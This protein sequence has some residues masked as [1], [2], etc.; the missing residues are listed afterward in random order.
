[1]KALPKSYVARLQD[2]FLACDQPLI[3]VWGWPWSGKRRL[4]EALAVEDPAAWLGLEPGELQDGVTGSPARWLVTDG[5]DDVAVILA[6]AEA[7]REDQRLLLPGERRLADEVLP[8]RSLQPPDLL[9][10]ADEIEEMFPDLAA[11]RVDELTRATDGWLGPLEWLLDHWAPAEPVDNAL[12]SRDFADAFHEHVTRA[13]DRESLAALSECSLVEAVDVDLWRRVWLGQPSQLAALERLIGAWGWLIRGPEGQLRL[14]RLL[15]EMVRQEP[16]SDD[17]ERRLFRRLGLAAHGLGLGE[18]AEHYLQRAGDASRL[19]RL[20]SLGAAGRRSRRPSGSTEVQANRFSLKLL[21]QPL[22]QRLDRLGSEVEL[23]W[24]LRR[25]LQSV[26]FLALAPD[27]RATKDE[28]IDAVWH[29]VAE[30]SIHKNFHPT[31]SEARRTLGLREALLYHQGLYSLNPELDW[32][33]DCECF[34]QRIERG[35]RLLGR[36]GAEEQALETWLE[37][38]SLYHG[39]LLAGIEAAWIQPLRE[40][41][42]LDYT[43]LLR[44]IGELSARLEH[45]TQALDAYRSLLLEEPF[46]ERIH[47]AVMELYALQ[48]RR[49]LVRR[50]FVRMQDL[51]LDELKVEPQEETQARYLELMR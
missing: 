43:E 19:T 38:W 6:A 27:R 21:G 30:S 24:S 14:P 51:L 37:A 36:S 9:L 15:R 40:S 17:R 3:E 11:A 22:V 46:E 2:R 7:L 42:Y 29:E 32:W 23:R 5:C 13:L 45:R 4:L 33:V 1:M 47:L 10:Q 41:L 20:R 31:L 50:Q 44:E 18:S 39:P 25:A 12:S 26:A 16:H 34:R 49:D 28:L 48:G 8:L 35:R